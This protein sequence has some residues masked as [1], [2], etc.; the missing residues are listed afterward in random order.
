VGGDVFQELKLCQTRSHIKRTAST[1]SY[2]ILGHS[3]PLLSQHAA[4]EYR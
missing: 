2:P 1:V 3:P 4:L